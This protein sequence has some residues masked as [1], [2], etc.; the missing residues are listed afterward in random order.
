[1][2]CASSATIFFGGESDVPPA[3]P[4]VERAMTAIPMMGKLFRFI[5]DLRGIESLSFR[6]TIR[7]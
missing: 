3:E 4:V 1:L 2:S 5:L 6:Y 7:H